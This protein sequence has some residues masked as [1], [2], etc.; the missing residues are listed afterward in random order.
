[1][2]SLLI[3]KFMFY[4]FVSS[5][6]LLLF[7]LAFSPIFLDYS[8]GNNSIFYYPSGVSFAFGIAFSIACL[9]LR[10]YPGKESWKPTRK[11]H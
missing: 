11:N 5:V 4:I 1:L 6:P 10:Y 9:V 7:G 8:L 2:I 3:E